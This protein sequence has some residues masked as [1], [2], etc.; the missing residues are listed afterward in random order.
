MFHHFYVFNIN[1]TAFNNRLRNTVKNYENFKKI[2]RF[3]LKNWV[4]GV[5]FRVKFIKVAMNFS[6]LLNL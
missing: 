4:K 5:D 3:T 1:L 2:T 6:F